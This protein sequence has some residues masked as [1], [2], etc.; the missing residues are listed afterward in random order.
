M[1]LRHPAQHRSLA[2]ILGWAQDCLSE[3]CAGTELPSSILSP[4]QDCSHAI[5]CPIQDCPGLPE[6]CLGAAGHGAHG[7]G[8]VLRHAGQRAVLR[9]PVVEEKEA[10]ERRLRLARQQ[11]AQQADQLRVALLLGGPPR[12]AG[13]LESVRVVAQHQQLVAAAK[14]HAGGH[15]EVPA[16]VA[17]GVVGPVLLLVNLQQDVAPRGRQ[18]KVRE[19]VGRLRPQPAAA[20]GQVVL[21]LKGDQR[22]AECLV[23]LKLLTLGHSA[24]VVTVHRLHMLQQ[25]PR[26]GEWEILP[27]TAF[28]LTYKIGAVPAFCPQSPMHADR[29]AAAVAARPS[30]SPMLAA[31][32]AAAVTALNPPPPVYADRRAAAR[33]A[34]VSLSPVLA[35]RRPAA[36]AAPVPLSPVLAEG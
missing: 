12:H 10:G 2:S 5:L 33:A 35:D 26:S 6:N 7:L 14:R 4:T 31:R 13:D 34:L 21:V 1:A 3:S 25:A 27:R 19:G 17:A 20:E 30:Q 29:R 18:G 23:H 22:V 9:V 16:H 28:N 24:R 32:R 15:V 8:P 36:V 11:P